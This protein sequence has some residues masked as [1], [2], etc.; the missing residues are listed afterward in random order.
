MKV[1]IV[2]SSKLPVPAVKGGAVP[3]LIEELIRENEKEKKLELHCCS[4][5][6]PEAEIKS[7]DY[8]QTHFVWA[9]TPGIIRCMDKAIRFLLGKVLKINRLLSLSYVFSVYWFA[10][11]VAGVLHK[12]NYDYVIFENSIPV[13]SALKLFGNKK[14]YAG[15][16]Y[17]HMHTVPRKYYGNERLVCDCKGLIS[18]SNFVSESMLADSRIQLDKEKVHI[19]YNC[20]DMDLF[21]PIAREVTDG[22]KEQYQVPLDK[23]IVLFIGRLCADK[24]IEEVIRSIRKLDRKDVVLLAVGGNFYKSGIVSPY[25]EHL[26]RLSEDIKDKIYFTGYVDYDRVAEIYAIA[27]VVVL[28]SVWDEPAGMTMVEA[29]ACGRPL[30]TTRSGGIPEYV[31]EGNCVLLERNEALVD[32][33]AKNIS[34]ILD[35][36]ER[37][38]ELGNKAYLRASQFCQ[39]FY[40]LQLLSILTEGNNV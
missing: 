34:E 37:A 29:M 4:L 5:F 12:E 8:K 39:Q 7:R 26:R 25:E 23:K 19:M 24:G 3:N 35:H 30:I 38:E 40:Y 6:D 21:K 14:K 20:I 16:Y 13:L 33:I 31:G 9:R 11:F 15:R 17:L 10:A 22:I 1:L 36:S 28:P 18:I 2:S 32:A 27:D